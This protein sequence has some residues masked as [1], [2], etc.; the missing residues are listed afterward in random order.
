[1]Y[2]IPLIVNNDMVGVLEL[3]SVRSLSDK[4]IDWL[5]EAQ[6][7]LAVGIQLT[8]NAEL[9]MEAEQR[10]SEQLKLN[11]QIINAIPNPTYFRNRKVPTLA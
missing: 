6:E 8:F 5:Q 3:G 7:D 10:V 9:Q 2:F 11:Q 4:E 1:M